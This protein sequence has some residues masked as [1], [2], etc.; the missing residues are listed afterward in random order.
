ME[1]MAITANPGPMTVQEWA[2]LPEDEPGEL[3]DGVLVEEE[4][5]DLTHETAVLWL[6][7]LLRTWVVALGGFAFASEVKYALSNLRGRK[8]DLSVFFPGRPALPRRGPVAIAPDIAV[9]I[10]S[11]GAADQRRDRIAKLADYAGFGVRFYWMLDPAARTFEILELGP[12]G[13]YVH[14]LGA[15]EGK[16]SQIPGCAGLT[17]DLDE[18]WREIERLDPESAP[19]A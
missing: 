2:A 16:L 13:R 14:A 12:G 8:P 15:S 11:P 18:L 5:A 19:Q 10:V 6:G 1:Q 7:T 17:L 3:C 9:E 4:V